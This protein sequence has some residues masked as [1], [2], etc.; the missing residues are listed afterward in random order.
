M[1]QG[2]LMRCE[3]WTAINLRTAMI[4]KKREGGSNICEELDFATDSCSTVLR[5]YS[6]FRNQAKHTYG[7][8]GGPVLSVA[9]AYEDAAAGIHALQTFQGLFGG[10]RRPFDF[11]VRNTW[12]FDFLRIPV[13]RE[14]AITEAVRAD[15][16]IVSL[17]AARELPA[18]TKWWIETT[19]E[20]RDGDPGA[21]VLLYDANQASAASAPSPAEEYLEQWARK[22]GLDFFVKRPSSGSRVKTAAAKVRH[23]QFS[24]HRSRHVEPAS[25]HRRFDLADW[26]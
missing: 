15:L 18:A 26:E 2:L 12:K 16:I 14:A 7:L 5:M 25:V 3:N 11:D 22:G 13:L 21:L 4:M 6:D 19:L 17:H 9:M 23:N 1:A 24:G 20:R 10:C 8:N